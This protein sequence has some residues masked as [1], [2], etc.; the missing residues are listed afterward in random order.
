[1][2]DPDTTELERLPP[3]DIDAEQ[4]A[5]GGMLLSKDAIG[6]VAEVLRTA[7]EFYR[8]AHQTIYRTILDLHGRGEPVDPITVAAE[9]T[10]RG[11]ITRA[12]GAAYLH[13]LVTA[14]PTAA[15]AE[16]YAEIVH[17]RAILRR[18]VEAGTRIATSGYKVDGDVEDIVDAAQAEIL[19][20][21]TERADDTLKP[22]REGTEAWL[23]RVEQGAERKG[24]ITGVPTSFE[25]LDTLTNGLQPGQ[26]V[27]VAARPAVGKSTFAL[28]VARSCAIHHGRTA[29]FFSLEMSRDELMDRIGAAE[30]RVQL[31]RI[32]NGGMDEDDWVR[33]ARRMPAINAAPLYIDD[34]AGLTL[35]GIC[36]KSR[37]LKQRGELHLVIVDYLQLVPSGATR[38]AESRQQEVADM[39]R[40]LKLLAKQLE[41]PVIALSQLNRGPEQRT[42]KKPMLSDLRESGAI[43]QDADMVIL[44]HREDAYDKESPRAGEADLIVAKHRNGPTVEIT[45][46]AELRFSRFVDLAPRVPRDLRS[47]TNHFARAQQAST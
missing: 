47:V 8:P 19:D 17:E 26:L 12:G 22:L 35:M 42:D 28:D 29:A 45:V 37:R 18:L 39:S 41:V 15:N 33:L 30:A 6:D 36:T 21:S 13:T 43:E 14:V 3:Q 40:K 34:D 23:D 32:R 11:E 5:L 16:Y 9:L 20:V 24:Q 44:L 46:K 38:R 31:H 1:M 10:R 2:T 25:D 4:S 27:V 7:A